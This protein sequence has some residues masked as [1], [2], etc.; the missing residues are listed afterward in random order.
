[1]SL[2]VSVVIPTYKRPE[3]L[4]KCL[5]ALTFQS[6]EKDEFEVVVVSDGPDKESETLVLS[7]Q[8]YNFRFLSLPEKKGPAA[9][10][11][12]GWKAAEAKLIAFTD[13]DTIPH[14]NWLYAFLDNSGSGLAQAFTGKI[15]VPVS[16]EPTD[17]E[18]N[19]AHL[20]QAD[21][22]TANC[23]L[24]KTALEM[25]NGFDER[26]FMAWREDSDLEFKL[27]DQGIPIRHIPE[28]L[29]VHPVRQAPWGISVKEQKKSMFNA[30]LYK[31]FPELYRERIQAGPCW[32]YYIMV[33]CVL[34]GCIFLFKHWWWLG[35]GSFFIYFLL[36]TNFAAR[37][38]LFTSKRRRHVWEMI[39]TSIVIPFVSVYWKLYG[40]FKFRV[41]YF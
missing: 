1:M 33:I 3:L 12:L 17:Y 6:L 16:E 2:K 13:D 31:K 9:A 22:V 23:A 34:L 26:F 38:L 11:N 10:R 41:L 27:L 37:R 21:F 39:L 19:T 28:A 18:K 14:S 29:V 15:K 30:L 35:A 40:A 7:Y 25:V 4:K 8:L 24:T 36:L 5:D 32:D 20:E